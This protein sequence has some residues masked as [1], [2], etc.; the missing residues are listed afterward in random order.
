MR[1]L[2]SPRRRV[3]VELLADPMFMAVAVLG[4]CLLG[5]SKGGFLGLGVM[6]LPLMSLFVPP[7][8]AAAIILPTAIAQDFLTLWIYRREWSAWNIKI[9]LPSMFCGMFIAWL[10]AASLSAAHIRLAI[11]LIATL[12]VLRHWTAK[13]LE[14]WTPKPNVA[15]GIIFGTLGGVTT[16]L[17]NAGGP[18]WQIHLL[19]QKL[20]KLPYIGTVSILFAAS[21]LVKIPGFFTLGFL[22]RDNLLIGLTLVPIAIASNYAG[23]W[24]V[25][26]VSTEMFFRI[27]YVLMFVI[28]V[29]LMRSSI[30]ELWR[31]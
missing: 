4:V 11:G 16:M 29:E 23:I 21:N 31:G 6:A 13:Y 8:Q 3:P 25:R 2:D 26:R 1:I 30:L 28:A 19:P 9:M 20:E 5:M 22:T 27:A 10:L 18:A 15:T 14:H 12:F 24:T 17:A 7:L